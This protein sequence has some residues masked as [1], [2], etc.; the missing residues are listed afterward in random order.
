MKLFLVLCVFICC[1]FA[2]KSNEIYTVTDEFVPKSISIDTNKRTIIE[3]YLTPDSFLRSNTDSNSFAYYLQ[4]LPL[5]KFGETVKYYDGSVKT[6]QNVYSSVVD[7]K[8]SNKDLQQCADAVMRLRA[9][10]LYEQKKYNQISFLFNGDKK[11]HSYLEYTQ[12]DRSYS[13][14]MNYMDYIFSYANT[15]SLHNQL[16]PVNLLDMQIGDVLVKKGN[17]YGHAVIVVDMC[18]NKSGEKCFMLAQSYMPAQET[19]IL[20]NPENNTV[21]YNLPPIGEI[22]TPEWTFSHSDLR[23]W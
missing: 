13:K 18:F 21:W 8:I 22:K 7:M 23:R 11:Y 4:H 10:Y 3:R 17:P 19:Q 2:E 15:G 12:N 20:L 14:F 16:K 6:N 5:K 1:N 9:E